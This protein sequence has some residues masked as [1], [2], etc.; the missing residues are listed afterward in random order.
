MNKFAVFE[1]SRILLRFMYVMDTSMAG[2]AAE[3]FT[4]HSY[5]SQKSIILI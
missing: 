2:S 3:T 5:K 1:C 4:F